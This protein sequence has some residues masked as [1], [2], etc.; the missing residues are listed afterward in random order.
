M[1]EASALMTR[2]IIGELQSRDPA[3]VPD[4]I[5]TPDGIRSPRVGGD[6]KRQILEHAMAHSGP[7]I[8][9]EIGQGIKNFA[10]A[11]II[12][13][14][15]NSRSP[16]VL[17]EKWARLER[18]GHS[19]NRCRIIEDASDDF[20][21]QRHATKGP[22]PTVAENLVICGFM[23]A[24]LELGGCKG[25]RCRLGRAGEPNLE[26]YSGGKVLAITKPMLNQ[27]DEWSIQWQ[28]F[29]NSKFESDQDGLLDFPALLK[30]E[31]NAVPPVVRN[32]NQ[33]ICEDLGRHWLVG[34][35]ASELGASAR[36]LQRR[37]KRAG[38]SFSTLVR[39]ARIQQAGKLLTGSE[40]SATEIG[41]C[42]GFTDSAHFS[43]DFSAGTGMSPSAY[44]QYA[45]PS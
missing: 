3:L 20:R 5:N 29:D 40:L 19:K 14:L 15:K 1:D 18:Y 43:R 8:I 22:V 7:E 27:T 39:A 11:P 37:F 23:I 26:V 17:A 41:Y 24:L 4:G 6:I 44:R 30:D 36:S 21:F 42:C 25:L 28:K 12:H 10:D 9:V 34:D 45:G 32:A 16:H 31:L 2:F 35:L 33:L 38:L 13:V